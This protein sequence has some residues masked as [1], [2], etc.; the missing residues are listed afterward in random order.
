VSQA[1]EGNISSHISKGVEPMATIINKKNYDFVRSQLGYDVGT[2]L[3]LFSLQG[4][5]FSFNWKHFVDEDKEYYEPPVE[6]FRVNGISI[7]ARII[8]WNQLTLF[9]SF[10][11][12]EEGN[13]CE[14]D[15]EN[16]ILNGIAE[17]IRSVIKLEAN[18][19]ECSVF[20]VEIDG[21]DVVKLP[22]IGSSVELFDMNQQSIVPIFIGT[23]LSKRLGGV[24]CLLALPPEQYRVPCFLDE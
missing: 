17:A 15:H 19:D 21:T 11:E 9:D 22:I 16:G 10:S 1:F 14:F 8:D 20:T 12:D 5:V 4:G 7:P 24:I 2:S 6:S 23:L 18:K 13:R 3:T